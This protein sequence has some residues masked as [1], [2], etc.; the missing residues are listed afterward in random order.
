MMAKTTWIIDDDI[1]SQFATR[2]CL[3]QSGNALSIETFSNAEEAIAQ[4]EAL[5]KIEQPL[6]ELVFLDLIMDEM[7]GWEFIEHLRKLLNGNRLPK[8]YILSAFVKS[9]DRKIAKTHSAVSG[10]FDKPL[11][12][13]SLSKVFASSSIN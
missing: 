6:P 12:R 2:Y 10:Y 7:D 11:S 8:I 1:V 5:L 4:L 3:E 9:K 13:V